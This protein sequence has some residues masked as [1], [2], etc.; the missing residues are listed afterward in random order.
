MWNSN[1]K[2]NSQHEY[3]GGFETFH[4]PAV[5]RNFG[6]GSITWK[7]HHLSQDSKQVLEGGY[8]DHPKNTKFS[9][10]SFLFRRRLIIS[11]FCF[12]YRVL[13]Y[14]DLGIVAHVATTKS[15][16]CNWRGFLCST[17][18]LCRIPRL[19]YP[20]FPCYHGLGSDDSTLKLLH[21]DLNRSRASLTSNNCMGRPCWRRNV[22][23]SFH[24]NGG[25]NKQLPDDHCVSS[26]VECSGFVFSKLWGVEGQSA[27]SVGCWCFFLS[28]LL[29]LSGSPSTRAHDTTDGVLAR[30][31]LVHP[32]SENVS[33]RP[34]QVQYS[35]CWIMENT[36][37]MSS[38]RK[39]SWKCLLNTHSFLNIVVPLPAELDW[40]RFLT[41]RI[42]R[43]TR[44]LTWEGAGPGS[45]LVLNG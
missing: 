45:E 33:Y 4:D 32:Q 40:G 37:S 18:L 11:F 28:E 12:H 16:T 3:F 41:S 38:C 27:P 6:L 17:T 5:P 43:S 7:C 44:L 14:T 22:W 26:A 30:P 1:N 39:K 13:F 15:R 19:G 10:G 35:K 36:Y 8:P 2:S 25:K 31:T 9:G 29:G 42:R 24:Q 20:A 21:W 23:P 34:K